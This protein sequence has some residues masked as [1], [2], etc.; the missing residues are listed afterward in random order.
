M[1]KVKQKSRQLELP[2]LMDINQKVASLPSSSNLMVSDAK[3][4]LHRPS[5]QDISVYKE[6]SSDYFQSLKRK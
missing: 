5:K 1:A 6:I 4:L 3:S 2:M